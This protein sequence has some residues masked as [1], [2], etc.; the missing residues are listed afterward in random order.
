MYIL[1]VSNMSFKNVRPLNIVLLLFLHNLGW[2]KNLWIIKIVWTLHS[3]IFDG[4][5]SCFFAKKRSKIFFHPNLTKLG[6]LLGI[7]L[8]TNH[9]KNFWNRTKGSGDMGVQRVRNDSAA[10]VRQK[11]GKNTIVQRWEKLEQRSFRNFNSTRQSPF[12]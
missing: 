10:R 4:K 7:Y 8:R 11:R 5:L 12:C 2:T 3:G 1:E 9:A 6:C